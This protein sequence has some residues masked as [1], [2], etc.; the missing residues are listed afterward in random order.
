M[1]IYIREKCADCGGRGITNAT[2]MATVDG[3]R[4]LP[5]RPCVSCKGECMIEEWISVKEFLGL[6]IAQK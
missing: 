5:P 6:L 2:L 3:D 4:E 1:E